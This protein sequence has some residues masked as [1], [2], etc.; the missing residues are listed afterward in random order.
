MSTCRCSCTSEGRA[1]LTRGR[2]AAC[3]GTAEEEEEEEEEE[4]L[5]CRQDTWPPS[6][7]EG[8]GSTCRAAELPG[9]PLRAPSTVA[10][11]PEKARPGRTQ[12]KV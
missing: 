5:P 10:L 7:A 11:R 4:A 9:L 8:A 1:L 2:D 3:T 12:D 6:T